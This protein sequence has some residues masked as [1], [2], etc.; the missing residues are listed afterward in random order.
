MSALG[1]QYVETDRGQKPEFISCV[2]G[3]QTTTAD[4]R[5]VDGKE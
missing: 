1:V 3:D 5:T 2:E 4:I